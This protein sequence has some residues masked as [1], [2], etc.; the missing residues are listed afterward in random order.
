MLLIVD[1]VSALS[2]FQKVIFNESFSTSNFQLVISHSLI[3]LWQISSLHTFDVFS[4][5]CRNS[6][7]GESKMFAL[8][9]L[10]ALH[11]K[12]LVYSLLF[13]WTSWN[14]LDALVLTLQSTRIAW[15]TNAFFP[16][17][18]M[19]DKCC[20]IPLKIFWFICSPWNIVSCIAIVKCDKI[21]SEI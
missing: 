18:K 12:Y 7:Y 21:C 1:S 20:W 2:H 13:P 10:S 16:F 4:F 17:W 6:Y 19:K 11:W 14:L 15:V 8:W 5:C 9:I 3:A